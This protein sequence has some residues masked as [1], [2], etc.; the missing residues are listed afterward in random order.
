MF[1]KNRDMN[2][3]LLIY[4]D[5]AELSTVDYSLKKV[6]FDVI[7]ISSEFAIQEKILSFNPEIVIAYGRGPKVTTIGVGKR[8]KEMTRWGGKSLLIFPAGFKPD[9]QD[10]IRA[11]MDLLLEAPIQVTRLIQ[12]LAKITNQDDQQLLEKLIKAA[13]TESVES[14]AKSPNKVRE[15]DNVF[16]GGQSGESDDT[17]YV[18]GSSSDSGSQSSQ[19]ST[20]FK[21][22]TDIEKIGSDAGSESSNEAFALDK[23]GSENKKNQFTL[24]PEAEKLNEKATFEKDSFKKDESFFSENQ[25]ALKKSESV[26]S[27]DPFEQMKSELEGGSEFPDPKK[28]LTAKEEFEAKPLIPPEL[29]DQRFQKELDETKKDLPKR[30]KKYFEL[31]KE[32]KLNEESSLQRLRVRKEQNK[33]KEDWG[34]TD[35]DEQDS[36]RRKFTNALFKKK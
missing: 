24:A 36:L 11:R 23:K 16:V 21:M 22:N 7:S 27:N 3:I 9:P 19:D 6:G 14:N 8:L 32:L 34:S 20:K 4:D 28:K 12:I 10:L 5:F 25:A 31:T 33:L 13:A 17:Q 1:S 30:T 18:G 15:D 26:K 35:L 29:V 2:K